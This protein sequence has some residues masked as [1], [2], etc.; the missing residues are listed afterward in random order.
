MHTNLLQ[1][2]KKDLISLTFNSELYIF[3]FI[4]L[5]EACFFCRNKTG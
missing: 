4:S 1:R 5:E 3:F 2:N